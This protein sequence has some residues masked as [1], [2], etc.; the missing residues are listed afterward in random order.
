MLSYKKLFMYLSTSTY[1]LESLKYQISV[2]IPA[3][4]TYETGFERK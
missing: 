4:V 3:V 1:A 2:D